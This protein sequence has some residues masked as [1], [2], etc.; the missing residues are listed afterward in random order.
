MS[1]R[2]LIAAPIPQPDAWIVAAELPPGYM[3]LRSLG[4]TPRTRVHAKLSDVV[5]AE[6]VLRAQLQRLLEAFERCDP[7]GRAEV[8]TCAEVLAGAT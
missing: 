1:A 2:L 3:V 4:I 8:V 6:D 7:A 5:P